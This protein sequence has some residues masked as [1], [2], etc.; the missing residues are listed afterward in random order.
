MFSKLAPFRRQLIG[1]RQNYPSLSCP[2]VANQ[3]TIGSDKVAFNVVSR[4]FII[5][6]CIGRTQPKTAT[7]NRHAG[8]QPIRASITRITSGSMCILKAR[9]EASMVMATSIPENIIPNAA[10]TTDKLFVVFFTGELPYFM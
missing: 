3:H 7:P 10:I 8:I 4:L 9:V 5:V 1:L 6:Q 2:S